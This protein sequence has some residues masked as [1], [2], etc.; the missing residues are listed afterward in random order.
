M[1]CNTSFSLDQECYQTV[2]P[3]PD[4]YKMTP[5]STHT[6]MVSNTDTTG[7]TNEETDNG[8]VFHPLF[9]IA[10]SVIV[11]C[12]EKFPSLLPFCNP[13]QTIHLYVLGYTYTP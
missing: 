6:T 9:K 11:I 13:K 3:S 5:S 12:E 7:E 2:K 8:C 4:I 1:L 10:C